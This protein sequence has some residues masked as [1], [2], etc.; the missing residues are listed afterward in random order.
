MPAPM[1]EAG[2]EQ[3]VAHAGQRTLRVLVAKPG[4]DTDVSAAPRRV[5]HVVSRPG[6]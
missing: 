1:S 6:G 3:A 4:L 5:R 2:R